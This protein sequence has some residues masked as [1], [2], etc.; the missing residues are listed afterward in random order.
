MDVATEKAQAGPWSQ[1]RPRSRQHSSR[2]APEPAVV[3]QVRGALEAASSKCSKRKVAEA[4]SLSLE[5]V[6]RVFQHLLAQGVLGQGS[7]RHYHLRA[8]QGESRLSR[9]R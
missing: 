1:C 6:D 5:E 2:P 3:A 7:N 8:E 4:L 9:T